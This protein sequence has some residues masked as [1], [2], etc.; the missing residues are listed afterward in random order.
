ML[1]REQTN[2]HFGV[3]LLL[4]SMYEKFAILTDL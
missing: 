2:P 1:E 3:S 4:S